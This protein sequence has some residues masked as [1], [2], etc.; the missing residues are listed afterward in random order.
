MSFLFPRFCERLTYFLAR[1]L[2]HDVILPIWKSNVSLTLMIDKKAKRWVSLLTFLVFSYS[3][4][5]SSSALSMRVF[6]KDITTPIKEKE[7]PLVVSAND[8]EALVDDADAT[9]ET[10]AAV[11]NDP[12]DADDAVMADL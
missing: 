1:S 9:D 3:D 2:S 11:D 5:N 7:K 6:G 12:A 4:L 10:M 8:L